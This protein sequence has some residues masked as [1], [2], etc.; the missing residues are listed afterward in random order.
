M[1]IMCERE[2]NMLSYSDKLYPV[3]STGSQGSKLKVYTFIYSLFSPLFLSLSLWINHVNPH[4]PQFNFGPKFKYKYANE[5]IA[6]SYH[7]EQKENVDGPDPAEEEATPP[8]KAPKPTLA[9]DGTAGV[10]KVDESGNGDGDRD[11]NKKEMEEE[12]P[13][14]DTQPDIFRQPSTY[15]PDDNKADRERRSSDLLTEGL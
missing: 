8:S 2:C 11:D 13:N 10:T 3:C 5:I 14:G 4:F 15:V 6:A 1:S 7:P 12:A 9:G